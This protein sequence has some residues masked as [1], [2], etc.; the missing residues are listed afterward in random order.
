LVTGSIG[1]KG[2]IG[3]AGKGKYE[4]VVAVDVVAVTDAMV[5]VDDA[6]VEPLLVVLSAVFC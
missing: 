3:G 6:A 1:G 4:E 5:E 2:G